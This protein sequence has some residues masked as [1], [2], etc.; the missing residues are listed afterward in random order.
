MSSARLQ[1][2]ELRLAKSIGGW[3]PGR[4]ALMETCQERSSHVIAYVPQGAD[5]G[6]SAR[7]K[8][9]SRETSDAAR[10]TAS[11]A[12]RLAGRQHDEL[13]M[14]ETQLRDFSRV[15]HPRCSGARTRERQEGEL[16]AI[17]AEDG[18]AGEMKNVRRSE[19]SENGVASRGVAGQQGPV[20]IEAGHSARFALGARQWFELKCRSVERWVSDDERCSALTFDVRGCQRG[21]EKRGARLGSHAITLD[22]VALAFAIP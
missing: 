9:A 6:R 4:K 22:D 2:L 20:S 10:A 21:K 16:W 7:A 12:E 19:Q 17:A 15:E 14:G 8:E 13:Q 11:S 18:V 5:N 3:N 1:R